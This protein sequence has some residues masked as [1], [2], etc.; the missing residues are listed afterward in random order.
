[1]K[2]NRKFI[3]VIALAAIVSVTVAATDKIPDTP[4]YTN[5]KVLPKNISS[6]ELQGIMAD[7][8]D[9]GLGVSCGFCHAGNKDGHG[10]DFASDAKPEK[11]ITRTMMRMTLGINK[12][13][14]K[15]KHPEIGNATLIVSCTTCHKGQAFPDG[16][17]PK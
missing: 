16:A 3:A 17:E 15:V 14:L 1:M 13:Y 10:L 2:I 12:K 9:D 4:Q 8:F 5:L 11:Q 6:K 7:D